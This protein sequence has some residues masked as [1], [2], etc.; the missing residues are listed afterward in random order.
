[1]SITLNDVDA[2]IARALER[3]Q[4]LDT[5]SLTNE[6]AANDADI[7]HKKR[8]I[9]GL[10]TKGQAHNAAKVGIEARWKQL[11]ELVEFVDDRAA[12]EL[13]QKELLDLA[14]IEQL[15]MDSIGSQIQDINAKIKQLELKN[16]ELRLK[17]DGIESRKQSNRHCAVMVTPSPHVKPAT[18]DELLWYACK[19]AGLTTRT[20]G[21]KMAVMGGLQGRASSQ[22]LAA[23]LEKALEL[24]SLRWY[25]SDNS[26]KEIDALRHSIM[27]SGVNLVLL[28]TR[29]LGH[30]SDVIV[31]ACRINQIPCAL[32]S[33]FGKKM[34]LTEIANLYGKTLNLEKF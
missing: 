21:H 23:C 8:E 20:R 17:K 5:T 15:E 28:L 2:L 6:I 14:G 16:V 11:T 24:K 27:T 19:E 26:P 1:V 18:E 9:H 3:K 13:A 31:K 25:E 12:F 4:E 22:A 32:S 7:E 10:Q 30:H 33:T 29:S 34:A